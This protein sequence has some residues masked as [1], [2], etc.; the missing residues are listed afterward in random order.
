MY[1]CVGIW[2]SFILNSYVYICL[3][4]HP[5]LTILSIIKPFCV[6]NYFKQNRKKMQT[7]L[8]PTVQVLQKISFFFEI[9][10]QLQHFSKRIRN[11]VCKV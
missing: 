1:T 5:L 8:N 6:I 9:L 3:D 11:T 7:S 10:Y 2:L 4:L